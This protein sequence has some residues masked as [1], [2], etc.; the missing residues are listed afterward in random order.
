MS[1][2]SKKARILKNLARAG[3]GSSISILRDE[4]VK[5][6]PIISASKNFNQLHEALDLLDS[7]AYRLPDE[8]FPAISGLIDRMGGNAFALEFDNPAKVRDGDVY[9]NVDTLVGKAFELIDHF[10]Y[11]KH[12]EV[13]MFLVACVVSKNR[14]LSSIASNSLVSFSEIDLKFTQKNGLLLQ[15]SVLENFE[16]LDKRA[17][18]E[19]LELLT[20][21]IQALLK[22]NIDSHTWDYDKVTIHQ[23]V[24]AATEE[25]RKLRSRL[26]DLCI[27]CY[28]LATG[29]PEKK[30]LLTTLNSGIHIWH[31]GRVPEG[32]NNMIAADAIRILTFLLRILPKE[33]L[34]IIQQ[35]EH[36]SFWNFY[37][38]SNPDVSALC[39][40][41]EKQINAT[42]EYLIYRDLVG[43]DGIFF[44]WE[45]QKQ[46]KASRI[47]TEEKSDEIVNHR[48]SEVS[49]GTVIRWLERLVTFSKTQSSDLATFPRMY[50]FAERV[51]QR[52]PNETFAFIG[53]HMDN[54]KAFIIP[55]AKGLWNSNNK[56]MVHSLL[57]GWSTSEEWLGVSIQTMFFVTPIDNELLKEISRRC[58]K[59][60]NEYASGL[61]IEFLCDRFG[62]LPK[63]DLNHVFQEQ[64]KGL[65][66]TNW[67]KF[68]W[69]KKQLRGFFE[70]LAG[71][72]RQA[73]LDNLLILQRI[74]HQDEAILSLLSRDDIPSVLELFRKRIERSK[75]TRDFDAI[76][77]KFYSLDEDLRRDPRLVVRTV[78]DWYKGDLY[79]FMYAG[80]DVVS[81][82]FPE[83]SGD[84]ENEL[85]SLL[86]T[87]AQENIEFVIAVLRSYNGEAFSL[88]LAVSLVQALPEGSALLPEV[89]CYMES[90]GVTRGEHGHSEGLAQKHEQLQ[91]LANHADPKVKAYF[92]TYLSG[93]K[94][95]QEHF[96]LH[97]LD[98]ENF[99]KH[100]YGKLKPE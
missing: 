69:Y 53:P 98:R 39:L 60:R 22:A 14:K 71:E 26:I 100:E 70:L 9:F 93:L 79:A 66:S 50:R 38:S 61:L 32:T 92:S 23:G 25:S 51:A 90:L 13:S 82:T 65:A 87:K 78:R 35:I 91:G 76:P 55:V 95:R 27:S 97:E 12:E 29:I 17:F 56:N 21:S 94:A 33:P 84:F 52:F 11:T 72:S 74:D 3:T 19:N 43:Y 75:T 10:K 77:F 86:D 58:V 15:N 63:N 6:H 68:V 44:S 42:P 18:L 48:V 46:T 20:P 81:R 57:K 2:E 40:Q 67:V 83:I 59:Y 28:E 7:F 47:I 16:R 89:E 85:R 54:C 37:H 4:F 24:I 49:S 64:L 31:P 34:E 88:D 1:N 96:R 45:E 73:I 99:R 36:N 41:I 5:L 8:I 80:A 62:D 30:S